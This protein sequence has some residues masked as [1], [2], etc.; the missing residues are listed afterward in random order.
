MVKSTTASLWLEEGYL[1]FAKHGPDT[2]RVEKL[3]RG[4]HMNKS[5][6]YHYFGDQEGY[7]DELLRLHEL[8]ASAYLKDV[9]LIRSIDPEYFQLLMKH[10][11]S[12]LFHMQLMRMRINPAVARLI[13]VIDQEE[14]RVLSDVWSDFLGIHERPQLAARYFDLVRGMFYSR[15]T[16][17]NFE[18]P[19]LFELITEAR[20]LMQDLMESRMTA[21]QV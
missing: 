13:E 17:A 18:Y 16:F 15:I 2:V 21:R 11:V 4:I 1:L 8:K 10:K 5:G 9:A 19:Y 3:A 12:T 20:A 7:W 14:E 6:F